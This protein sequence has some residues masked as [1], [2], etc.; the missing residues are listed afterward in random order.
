MSLVAIDIEADGPCPGEFSMLSFGAVMVREGLEDTFYQELKPWTTRFQQEAMDVNGL[1]REKLFET[2]M[3][4]AEAMSAFE[5]WLLSKTVGRPVM[6]SDNPAY[7]FQFVN[8]YFWFFL[9]RNPL[10]WSARRLPDIWSGMQGNAYQT[11]EWN[12]YSITEHTHNALDDAMGVAEA[13]LALNERG[14]KGELK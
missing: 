10:G 3:E 8:Y 6:I 12:Q 2:G 1:D 7:D 14:W 4:P 13:T 9:N 5:F 11:R